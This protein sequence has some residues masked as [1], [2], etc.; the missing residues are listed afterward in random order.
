AAED[1]R[2]A[3]TAPGSEAEWLDLTPIQRV[4]GQRMV[5]S[6]QAAPHF[7]LSVN[8]D[9]T[10]AL[11]LR[12]ALAQTGE[13]L[14]VTA[15]L[16][17]VVATALR[18]HPRVNA[19]FSEGRIRLH[20]RIN[21]GVAVASEGG[22]LVPVIRDAD[23]K[24]LTEIAC[25]LAGLQ[26]RAKEMRL[27]TADLSGGTF[28]ISNLGMYGIERFTAIINPPESAILAVGQIVRT[29][30]GMPDDTVALRPLMSLTLSVD[31]RSLDGLQAAQFLTE[32]KG[33]LEQPYL[34]L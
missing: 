14:T 16:V 6:S 30:V 13:R 12:E 1:V 31:H 28:T 2:T 17:K 11:E 9:M 4:T 5:E 22:L 25:E 18:R 26:Q 10:R 29:P 33:R 34:L 7:T 23:G 19:S 20:R 8:V 15:I 24:G 32:V 27:T 21:V 3:P